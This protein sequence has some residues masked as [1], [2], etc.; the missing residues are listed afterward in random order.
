MNFYKVVSKSTYHMYALG[1]L[2]KRLSSAELMGTYLY[3][4]S[5][6]IQQRL[7]DEQ[8]ELMVDRKEDWW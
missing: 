5:R 8:V 3:V 6:G 4:N 2:V 1:E 7:S